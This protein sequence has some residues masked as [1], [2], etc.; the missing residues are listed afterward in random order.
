MMSTSK[1][2]I[3]FLLLVLPA[4]AQD[5]NNKLTPS[6]RTVG[7]STLTIRPDRAQIDIGVVTQADTSQTAAAKNATQLEN[8]LNQLKRLLGANADIKTISY[9]LTPTYR[10]PT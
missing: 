2:L 5:V 10:Y 7:E 6:V 9:S 1:A 8:T 4:A 3:L